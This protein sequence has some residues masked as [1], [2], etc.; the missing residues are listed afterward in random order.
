MPDFNKGGAARTPIGKNVP[1][2][3]TKGLIFDNGTFSKDGIPSVT[4]DGDA[5]KILQ[6]GTIVAK[7]TSGTFSGKLGVF[8]AAATD[9]RQTAANIVG[10]AETFL[11]WQLLERDV[12]I[13]FGIEGRYVQAACFEYD[14]GNLRIALT[15]TT[16]DAIYA[17]AKF[18]NLVFD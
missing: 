17:L 18:R 15:N 8:S 3:S 12:E 6:P 10:V 1:Y 11:P 13:A 2:S 4:I 9:G 16:R 14:A 5:T 7:A